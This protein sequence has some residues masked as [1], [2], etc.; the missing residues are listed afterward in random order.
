MD[1]F[2]VVPKDFSKK[3]FTAELRPGDLRSAGFL[4][5]WGILAAGVYQIEVHPLR[6]LKKTSIGRNLSV[7]DP[8]KR[9]RVGAP[10]PGSG[11]ASK[12]MVELGNGAGIANYDGSRAG[13]RSRGPAFVKS[14]SARQA[15]RKKTDGEPKWLTPIETRMGTRTRLRQ[16]TSARQAKRKKT[17]GEPKWLTPIETRMGTRTRLRQKHS[18]AAGEEEEDSGRA[19]VFNTDRDTDGDEDPPSSKHFGAAGE[20]EEDRGRAGEVNTDGDGRN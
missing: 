12:L 13:A 9:L 17:D 2:M 10:S 6:F 5:F 19:E 15:K 20:E 8:R 16:S 11:A 3:L 1:S 18:G 7:V 14:T 4:T